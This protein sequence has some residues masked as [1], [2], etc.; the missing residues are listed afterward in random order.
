MEAGSSSND[1]AT[2][3]GVSFTLQKKTKT[4]K[5]KPVSQENVETKEFLHSSD[6][7]RGAEVKKVEKTIPLVV[8]DKPPILRGQPQDSLLT[9]TSQRPKPVRGRLLQWAISIKINVYYLAKLTSSAHNIDSLFCGCLFGSGVYQ[10]YGEQF[11]TTVVI[12][13]TRTGCC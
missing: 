5:F 9:D 1:K 12:H 4:T 2:A 6:D 7:F 8:R 13:Y 3:P 10:G 11:I